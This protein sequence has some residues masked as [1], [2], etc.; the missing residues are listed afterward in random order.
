MVHPES[1]SL[2]TP[3]AALLL[4][5]L[6]VF[7]LQFTLPLRTAAQSRADLDF[8]R[9]KRATVFI[10]QAT[11][12]DMGLSVTCV[13]TGTLISADGLIITNAHGVLPSTRCDGDTLI[14]SLNVDLDEPPIPKYRAIVSGADQG[15]D[16]ALLRIQRE[17]DGRLIARGSLPALPFVDVGDAGAVSID[18]NVFVAGYPDLGDSP[19]SITRGTVTALLAEPTDRRA[20]WFKTRAVIPGTM[21]GGGAYNAARELIGIPTNAPLEDFG[22]ASNCLFIGDTNGDGLV[23]SSDRCVPTGDF[24]STIRPINVAASLIR[25]ARLNLEVETPVLPSALTQSSSSPNVSRLFFAPSMLDRLPSTVVGSL[26]GNTRSLFLLFDYDYMT[27]ET[28]Y[29]LRVTRDGTPETVFSLPPVR[30]SGGEKGLWHIGGREQA[31]ANGAY[32]FSLLINGA[33]AGN[34]RIVIGGASENRGYFSDIVFGT[35]DRRGSL[36]GNGSIVPLGSIATARFLYANM[37]AGTSW[38][39][40]WY[41]AGIEVARTSNTWSDGANGAKSISLAPAEGLLPGNYRL[42]LYIEG[43]LSATSDFVVA[44][45][46]GSPLPVIFLNLRLTTAESPVAARS[47][48]AVSSFS[49]DIRSLYALFDWQ[50]I[51]AGTPWTLRWLVD[52]RVFYQ[53]TIP[54]RN[55]ETGKDFTLSLRNPPDGKYTLQLLVSELQL[56][57]A[58]AIVGIGQL[59]IDRFAEAGGTI[60]AG[61][62]VDAAT[63]VGLPSVTIVLISEDYAASEFVWSQEQVFDQTTTDRNGDFQFGRSLEFG[64]PYSMVIEAG[65]YLPLAADEF[66]FE[67]TEPRADILIELVRG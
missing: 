45:L 52:D 48:A 32:E 21:A 64:T 28:V 12:S 39:A 46:P 61:K 62:V 25:A 59:P 65:G 53:Q 6:S 38:S 1:R 11:S 20:A 34:Q 63:Q 18:D 67:A 60:L 58:E 8:D 2:A 29:E 57:E 10:Y 31:W 3:N 17:L 55:P 33:S 23:N 9:V 27:P 47:A 35:L 51:A 42:E 37:Q 5:W 30:W 22:A 14:V 49:T 66:S 44:G 36:V 4:F 15:L 13:S 54:W 40:I 56:A 43:A 7:C 41:F 26:P 19:V 50:S 24:I 16:I